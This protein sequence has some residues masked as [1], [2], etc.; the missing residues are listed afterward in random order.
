[1]RRARWEIALRSTSSR[2]AAAAGSPTRSRVAVRLGARGDGEAGGEDATIA[3]VEVLH[4]RAG[5]GLE[6]GAG[7]RGELARGDRVGDEG[8]VGLGHFMSHSVDMTN[9]VI[10]CQCDVK[11]QPR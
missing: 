7:S 10:I 3:L 5:V 9:Y 2:A 1:M 4:G 11:C 8:D 6:A